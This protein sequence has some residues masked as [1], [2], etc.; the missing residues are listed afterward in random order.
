MQLDILSLILI[1]PPPPRRW[2]GIY[3]PTYAVGEVTL[4]EF[5]KKGISYTIKLYTIEKKG[6]VV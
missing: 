3:H 2:G 5:P 1:R 6:A 4:I